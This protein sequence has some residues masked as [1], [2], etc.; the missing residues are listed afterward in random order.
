MR[1]DHKDTGEALFVG[2]VR[3]ELFGV[4]IALEMHKPL[5]YANFRRFH[6]STANLEGAKLSYADVHKADVSFADFRGADLTG[7]DFTEAEMEGVLLEGTIL[8]GARMP[9]F[10][11]EDP[12]FNAEGVNTEG[13]IW[14]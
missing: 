11:R 14:I 3:S 8:T 7:A 13:V 5:A 12:P 1:I 4:E 9:A 10:K 6:L 2:L